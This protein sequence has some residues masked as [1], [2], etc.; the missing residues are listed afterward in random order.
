[1]GAVSRGLVI[2]RVG[3]N[4]LHPSWLEP[5]T[6][7]AW[8]LHL[9]PFQPI[10]GQDALDCTV[11]EVIPGPKWT[12]IRQLLNEWDGWRD[13]DYI[14]FPDDDIAADQ[15]TI[16]KMFEVA[17]GVGLELFAPALHESSYYAH[18][19]T[20]RNTSF[21]GRWVGFVEIMVPGFSVRALERL[22]PTLDLSVTGWGW[23]LD[24]L[25]P[26]LLEYKNVGIVDAAPVVHTRPVGEMRDAELK[27][28]VMAESDAILDNHDCR[29]VHTTFGAFGPDLAPLELSPH[30][31]FAQLVKGSQYLIDR[32][33]R[34][35][36]WLVDFQRA[37]MEALEYPIEGTP[38][39]RGPAR[40]FDP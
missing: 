2:A 20:M 1:M 36:S 23:G 14:W 34:V 37:Q 16:A 35:L 22:R 9:C 8:D 40:I 30:E 17:H 24:S 3:A 28:R 6:P 11:G 7:R 25:W 21:Y 31:F 12:G 15:A 26:K 33:P 27:A 38:D 4:S 39:G 13:Y 10:P 19:I 18:F 32:D 5:G 29:Q